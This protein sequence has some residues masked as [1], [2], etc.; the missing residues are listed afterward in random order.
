LFEVDMTITKSLLAGLAMSFAASAC[1]Q[2]QSGNVGSTKLGDTSHPATRSSPLTELRSACGADGGMLAAQT[3]VKRVPYLQQ[4]TATSAMV[5]WVTTMPEGQSIEITT[6]GAKVVSATNVQTDTVGAPT[7]ELQLW[8]LA[9]TLEPDTIY[10]YRVMD[11]GQALTERIGFRTAPSRDSNRTIGVLAFGDSGAGSSD[12]YSLLGQMED[13]PYEVMI[14]TGDLAYESG[15]LSEIEHNVFDVYSDLF[16]HIPFY[17]ASGNHDYSTLSGAPFR[18]VFA[19]PENG[20]DEKWYSY[21]WGRIH[22]VALDTESDYETQM[23][24]LDADLSATT[25]PW[26]IVYLHRPPYS[27]GNHGSDT[28]LRNLIAPILESRGVQLLLSGHDHHY[29]RMTPQNGVQYIVTGG[30][31]RGTYSTGTSAFT[32]FSESVIHY[33]YLEVKPDEAVLHAIDAEG[34]EFDSVVVPR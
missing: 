22:F 28:R 11:H 21:D 32:A 1:D 10:C 34:T 29:E 2:N 3:S 30:G 8:S 18:S 6:P 9:D 7:G 16:R 13:V 17:P 12:Q 14:H 33:V 27:S 31:G 15:T 4:V 26:K 20:N 24:W 23:T 25:L 19:L 5:G